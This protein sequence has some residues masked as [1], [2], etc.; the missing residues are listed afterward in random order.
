MDPSRNVTGTGGLVRRNTTE[1]KRVKKLLL[2]K[3]KFGIIAWH[4]AAEMGSLKTLEILRRLA[5]EAE[6]FLGQLVLTQV[7]FLHKFWWKYSL[8]FR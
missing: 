4:R 2:V 3:Y 8:Y 6:L 5:M 7:I 1:F